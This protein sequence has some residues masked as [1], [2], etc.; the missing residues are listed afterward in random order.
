MRFMMFYLLFFIKVRL[1]L[2]ECPSWD[3]VVCLSSRV[4]LRDKELLNKGMKGKVFEQEEEKVD[5]KLDE[6]KKMR[7]VSFDAS[8]MAKEEDVSAAVADEENQ[9]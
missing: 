7:K 8:T 2:C 5:M 9:K 3:S 4:A 1:L 6:D